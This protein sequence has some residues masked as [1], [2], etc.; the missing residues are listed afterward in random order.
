MVFNDCKNIKYTTYNKNIIEK[1]IF[2]DKSTAEDLNKVIAVYNNEFKRLKINA[3]V[4]CV[5]ALKEFITKLNGMQTHEALHEL[6][7]GNM[8]LDYYM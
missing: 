5:L 1:K 2:I 6:K 7:N 4:I 3:S 8:Q